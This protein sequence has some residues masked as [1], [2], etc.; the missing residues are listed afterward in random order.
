MTGLAWVSQ[1]FNPPGKRKTEG[2][3]CSLFSV[4]SPVARDDNFLRNTAQQALCF[5]SV[6]LK[7]GQTIT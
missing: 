7:S 4:L 2:H 3:L 1:E 5:L 6:L